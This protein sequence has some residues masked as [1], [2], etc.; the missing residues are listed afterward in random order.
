MSRYILISLKKKLPLFIIC[1][2]LFAN[3]AFSLSMFNDFTVRVSNVNYMF[4]RYSTG[5]VF[6]IIIFMI[7][8]LI[9][10]FFSMNYRYS[11]TKS[12]MF[13][14]VPVKKNHIRYV[15]HLTTLGIVLI[16]FTLGFFFMLF[17]M[18]I[19]NANTTAMDVDP[20]YY[21]HNEII[22]LNYGYF[23]LAY[24]PMLIMGIG[25][26]FISY[27]FISR[28]N[29]LLNSMIMLFTGE[30]IVLLIFFLPMRYFIDEG[31]LH[32][33]TFVL[34]IMTYGEIFEPLITNR[35]SLSQLSFETLGQAETANKVLYVLE[36]VLFFS[37]AILGIV[38][39]IIEKD[40]SSEY[41]GK[42]NTNRPYQDIIYHLGALMLGCAVFN[43][44]VSVIYDA[45]S[46][47][48]FLAM[49]YT[50]FGLLNRSFVPKKKDIIPLSVTVG[51][52]IIYI[53]GLFIHEFMI[54]KTVEFL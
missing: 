28:S 24:L 33:A 38:A 8:M 7:F 18:M 30:M 49:Y 32:Q 19:K 45:M 34:P 41:A 50:F 44:H 42:A 1:V 27:L 26:Y 29:N 3:I 37:V 17:A 13:R 39:F 14:Q 4:E 31:Y 11:L 46:F 21:Y 22:H 2:V 47:V 9:L 51:S 43:L 10:P 35:F 16:A 20:F 53:L 52:A 15:E 48:F 12:D 40:P 6:Y 54:T 25:Q 36:Y 5:S 23:A